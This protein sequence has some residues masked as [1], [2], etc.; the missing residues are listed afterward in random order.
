MPLDDPPSLKK[1]VRTYTQRFFPLAGILLANGLGGKA[2]EALLGR[3][4]PLEAFL[5]LFLVGFLIYGW[6]DWFAWKR[7]L[8][9]ACLARDLDPGEVGQENR[10]FMNQVFV[11][12]LKRPVSSPRYLSSESRPLATDVWTELETMLRSP[13]YVGK[14]G[15]L[16]EGMPEIGK[17]RF[18]AEWL[19]SQRGGFY[20]LVPRAE[21]F[22]GLHWR[23]QN[24]ILLRADGI[25]LLLDELNKYE[26]IDTSLLRSVSAMRKKRSPR[27]KRP[28]RESRPFLIAATVNSGS[29]VR[30]IEEREDLKRLKDTLLHF[31]IGPPEYHEMKMVYDELVKVSKQGRVKAPPP[32]PAPDDFERSFSFLLGTSWKAMEARWGKLGEDEKQLLRAAKLL[33]LCR[34]AVNEQRWTRAAQGVLHVESHQNA[35]E[36]VDREGFLRDG[37]PEPSYLRNVVK[38]SFQSRELEDLV[39]VLKDMNDTSALVSMGLALREASDPGARRIGIGAI[40]QSLRLTISREAWKAAL[41]LGKKTRMPGGS[42]DA[43]AAAYHLGRLVEEGRRARSGPSGP[44][45]I[46]GGKRHSPKGRA[47]TAKGA[48]NHEAT[49][50]EKMW[51][52][53]RDA[54]NLG[55]QSRTPEG[56]AIAENARSALSSATKNLKLK[57]KAEFRATQGIAAKKWPKLSYA[58]FGKRA[59]MTG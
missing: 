6:Y 52:F 29:E 2:I 55:T 36:G 38:A 56:L 1:M 32:L 3:S 53:Y 37:S 22:P 44:L 49:E 51:S 4:L 46:P 16:L 59:G 14:W 39:D 26:K 19:R 10:P 23:L 8:S 9:V 40:D 21:T 48:F 41:A 5:G 24:R 50:R 25:C 47:S 7:Q 11:H 20:V 28:R 13:E 17:T 58:A 18:V 57:V 15:F 35:M 33:E 34:I 30:M 43:A 45:T 12:P 54:I 42:A 27:R 31:V